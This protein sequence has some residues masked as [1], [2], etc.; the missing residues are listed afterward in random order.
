LDS[1]RWILEKIEEELNVWALGPIQRRVKEM[2][3]IEIKKKKSRGDSDLS[4]VEQDELQKFIDSS[5]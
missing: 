5:F 2:R 3:E 4:E 1:I